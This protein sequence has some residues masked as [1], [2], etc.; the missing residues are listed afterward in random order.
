MQFVL[1]RGYLLFV[2][3]PAIMQLYSKNGRWSPGKI[4]HPVWEP[5]VL[6]CG[7][8]SRAL[9]EGIIYCTTYTVGFTD[10]RFKANFGWRLCSPSVHVYHIRARDS[11]KMH[12]QDLA[13]LLLFL[14]QEIFFS[15]HNPRDWRRAA[16]PQKKVL[17]VFLLPLL[18]LWERC[19]LIPFSAPSMKF[20]LIQALPYL[21]HSKDHDHTGFNSEKSAVSWKF[22]LQIIRTGCCTCSIQP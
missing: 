8:R 21:F 5:A 22:D 4:D 7:L 2:D 6:L 16:Q 9:Q 15:W 17:R 18:A 1:R 13:K 3:S 19:C 14:L 11:S 10:W 20:H 12:H